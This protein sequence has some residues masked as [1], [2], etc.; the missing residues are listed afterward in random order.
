M[1]HSFTRVRQTQLIASFVEAR[2]IAQL[3]LIHNSA[4]SLFKFPQIHGI[5]V[6]IL[7]NGKQKFTEVFH[8]F[9]L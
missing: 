5:Q 9:M 8:E 4:T 2:G 1:D 3:S 7:W 6:L